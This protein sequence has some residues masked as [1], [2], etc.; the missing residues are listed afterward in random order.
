MV[1]V[2]ELEAG[3]SVDVTTVSSQHEYEGLSDPYAFQVICGFMHPT[4]LQTV[5]EDQTPNNKNLKFV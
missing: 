5:L 4:L 1:F 3:Y 2:E